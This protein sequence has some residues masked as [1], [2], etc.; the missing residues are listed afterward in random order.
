VKI[1]KYPKRQNFFF[2]K[3]KNVLLLYMESEKTWNTLVQ[4]LNMFFILGAKKYFHR[5]KTCKKSIK[6][7]VNSSKFCWLRCERVFVLC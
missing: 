7:L 5:Y 3:V 4:Q 2:S 1:P 6:S